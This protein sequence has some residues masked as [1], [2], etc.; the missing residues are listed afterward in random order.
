[1]QKSREGKGK[2]RKS[3]RAPS[4][5]PPRPGTMHL[6]LRHVPIRINQLAR[7]RAAQEGRSV[8]ALLRYWLKNY[9]EGGEIPL[10]TYK[11]LTD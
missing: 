3:I 9:A 4:G 8:S 10:P 5:Q 11:R 7:E 2:P 6:F 1:M